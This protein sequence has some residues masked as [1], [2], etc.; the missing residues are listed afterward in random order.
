[1]RDKGRGQMPCRL[2]T[3]SGRRGCMCAPSGRAVRAS[4][5]STPSSKS[6]DQTKTKPLAHQP[7][8]GRATKPSPACLPGRVEARP[9]DGKKKAVGNLLRIN[10]GC[11]STRTAKA[12][13]AAHRCKAAHLK[14]ESKRTTLPIEYVILTAP[15]TAVAR[16]WMIHFVLT[17]FTHRKIISPKVCPCC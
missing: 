2:R 9:Q 15:G 11:A 10:C 3:C 17:C 16:P 5:S 1:M 13:G 12:K 6:T 4:R 7:S 8:L 14:E